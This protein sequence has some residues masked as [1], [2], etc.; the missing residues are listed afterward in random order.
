VDKITTSKTIYLK[1]FKSAYGEREYLR[2][3]T[4]TAPQEGEDSILIDS[5]D[6]TFYDTLTDADLDK[7]LIKCLEE[8]RELMKAAA[9][10]AIA[11]VDGQ[12]QSL[13]ALE[14]HNESA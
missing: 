6:V 5:M 2:Y 4:D 11:E 7:G 13:L 14:N 1:A 10:A 9:S 12:I 8:K 3:V